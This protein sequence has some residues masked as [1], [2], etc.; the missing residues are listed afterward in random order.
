MLKA[1][2]VMLGVVLFLLFLFL[3]NIPSEGKDFDFGASQDFYKEYYMS[4][5]GRIMDPQKKRITTSEGQAYMLIRT[6][7]MDDRTSFD[8]VYKWSVNN[9][10]RPDGL[11]S[12]LW[13]ENQNGEYK[14]LDANSASDADID[15]AFALLLAYEKWGDQKYLNEARFV[16]NSIWT[17]ETKPIG[18]FMVLMPG[19]AQTLSGKNE[20]NPSYFS[21]YAFKLFAKYDPNH[22]W[23]ELCD[24]SYRILNIVMSDNKAGLPPDWFILDNGNVVFEQGRSDFSY[25]AIRVF[26]RVF[27]DYKMTGDRRALHILNR[28][29][30]FIDR[31]KLSHNFYTNYKL[32]GEIKDNDKFIGSIAVLVPVINL[33]DEKVAAEIYNQ[34]LYPHFKDRNYWTNKY[35]YYGQNLLWFGC[36]LY[37]KIK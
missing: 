21:P 27:L 29:S 22:N 33:Y 12:W 32:N 31:W 14:I 4:K 5:D 1:N 9:L 24:S 30:F 28:V 16:I 19:V 6:L 36:Y 17:N 15:I 37:Q 7:L 11:F 2:T 18:G 10:K 3:I 26:P 23:G 8:L 35:D 25:D 34:E 20:I 13:G